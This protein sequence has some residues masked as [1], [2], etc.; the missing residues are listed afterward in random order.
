MTKSSFTLHLKSTL[1]ND[2]RALASMRQTE[3]LVSVICSFYQS[4][5][6]FNTLNTQ[7]ENL[8]M[9]IASV[10]ILAMDIASVI[11]FFLVTALGE[12]RLTFSESTNAQYTG[13]RFPTS[14]S[15]TV[16]GKQSV[17]SSVCQSLLH[18]YAWRRIELCTYKHI[19]LWKLGKIFSVLK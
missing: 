10:I 18:L 9:D 12:K 7:E 6:S 19:T 1:P 11:I 14:F 13:L 5:F 4:F 2:D 3:A 15:Y 16:I 8:T 17:S